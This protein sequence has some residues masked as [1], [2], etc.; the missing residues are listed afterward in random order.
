MIPML[1]IILIVFFIFLIS[2]L[3]YFLT[4]I[5]IVES[6]V[7][8]VIFMFLYVQKFQTLAILPLSPLLTLLISALAFS[9]SGAVVV[10]I[11]RKIQ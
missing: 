8:G 5:G 3:I 6:W 9:L 11:I 7:F 4:E 1:D 10:G 2:M